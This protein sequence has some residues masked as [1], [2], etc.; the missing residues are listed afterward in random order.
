MKRVKRISLL[1][2]IILIQIFSLAGCTSGLI[3]AF[4]HA[5]M[6]QINTTDAVK[7]HETPGYAD[8]LAVIAPN[9]DVMDSFDP[10]GIGTALLVDDTS[11]ET[12]VS[13]G[14]DTRI[15]PASMTKVM[16]G[17][18]IA[19]ALEN[20]TIS[21]EDTVKIHNNIP[22]DPEAAR[23]DLKAGDTITVKDLVYGYLV[24]SLNDCGIVLAELIAG[25]E[26]DF[27]SLMNEKA[28]T[29]GAT[30]THFVN[31]HGLHDENHYT[32]AYDLYLFFREFA[33]HELIHEIDQITKYVLTYENAEG[34]QV[35][36]EIEST[37]GFLSGAYNL[38]SKY[39]IGAW[40]SGTTRAAG[41]CLIMQVMYQ[42]HSYYA[43]ICK[44]NDRDTLYNRMSALVQCI[45]ET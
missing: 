45:P 22:L 44:A 18:L 15:Y 41:S 35:E 19:E 12:I 36:L 23:L 9:T 7:V 25:T 3:S 10:L 20:G 8:E 33:A 42:E 29:L 4:P 5:D 21:M 38:P 31:C 1:C 26:T 13:Y 37:N 43:V 11:K 16:S 27:V 34:E 39:Q 30:H 2:S 24:R 17:I 28:Y 32:T 40:K 14:G 6:I